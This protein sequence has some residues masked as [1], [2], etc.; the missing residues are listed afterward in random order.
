MCFSY[1]LILL[2]LQNVTAGDDGNEVLSFA[3]L[4]LET[5]PYLIARQDRRCAGRVNLLR[6][7]AVD[8]DHLGELLA[9]MWEA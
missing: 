3:D 2:L 9:L 7:C 5:F 8:G 4:P 1:D 6:V